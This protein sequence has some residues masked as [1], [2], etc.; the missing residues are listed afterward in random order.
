MVA[1]RVA[2][3]AELREARRALRQDLG[4]VGALK[5]ELANAG[6]LEPTGGGGGGGWSWGGRGWG[7]RGVGGGRG[8]RSWGIQ[9]GLL[10][11]GA[12]E[13]PGGGGFGGGWGSGGIWWWAIDRFCVGGDTIGIEWRQCVTLR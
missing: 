13:L 5:R 10:E 8:R 11:E 3:V 9:I 2:E 4:G 6:F 12:K 7:G 1:P